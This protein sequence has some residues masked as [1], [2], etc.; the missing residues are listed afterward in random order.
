MAMVDFPSFPPEVPSGEQQ[1]PQCRVQYEEQRGVN[2]IN[3]IVWKEDRSGEFITTARRVGAIKLWN[4]AQTSPK[5]VIKVGTHGVNQMSRIKG[6]PNR[7]LLAFTNG[8]LQV[9]NI[10][11]RRIEFQTEA[12]H[13][14]T[15]FDLEFCPSN[16]DLIASCSYDGTVRVWEA[17]SM[18]LV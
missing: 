14:E 13:A 10:A 2:K 6:D 12:G 7:L 1:I 18:K 15:V 5:E 16:K 4:V 3:C 9:F 11:R 17:S 8:A